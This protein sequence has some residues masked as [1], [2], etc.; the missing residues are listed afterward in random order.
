MPTSGG[1]APSLTGRAPTGPIED[2]QDVVAKLVWPSMLVRVGVERARGG[3]NSGEPRV[4][5][6]GS[7]RRPSVTGLARYSTI[8]A[9]IASDGCVRIASLLFMRS[10]EVSTAG[11]GTDK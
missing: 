4:A 9:F 7:K 11:G 10:R 3:H 2:A 8:A 6:V 1:R 5:P